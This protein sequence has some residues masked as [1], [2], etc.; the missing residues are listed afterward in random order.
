MR[1][2]DC[3]TGWPGSV[4]DSRVLKNSDFFADLKTGIC[5][6]LYCNYCFGMLWLCFRDAVTRDGLQVYPRVD[7]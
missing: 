5:F 2:I 1:F 4:H 6:Q 3:Y 7:K